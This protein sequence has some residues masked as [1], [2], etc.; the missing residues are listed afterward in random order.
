MAKDDDTLPLSKAVDVSRVSVEEFW[1]LNAGQILKDALVAEPNP[2]QRYGDS[3]VPLHLVP[4]AFKIMTAIG[5]DE[6]ANKYG[7]WNWR[8][9]KVEVMTYIG[10]IQRHLDAWVDG[11]EI[12][13]DS[14]VGKPHLAGAA[15]SL[16]IIIDALET[17][18]AIDNRPPKGAAARML[19]EHEADVSPD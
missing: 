2:K 8:D 17:G 14:L 6:G 7:A 3:K 12:D 9:I 19:K 16:A 13:P 11:E 15:A 5:L 10:A 18:H 4:A 1:N